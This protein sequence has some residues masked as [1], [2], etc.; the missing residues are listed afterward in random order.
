MT[1]ADSWPLIALAAGLA[2][3]AGRN[4]LKAFVCKTGDG[5]SHYF[6]D[7]PCLYG[8]PVEV[9]GSICQT[10]FLLFLAVACPL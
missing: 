5:P 4:G 10:G 2:E 3:L 9:L 7:I 6:V 1:E 8:L